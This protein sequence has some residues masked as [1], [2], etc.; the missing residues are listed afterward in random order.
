M[1]YWTKPNHNM[2]A[3]YQCSSIPFVTSSAADEVDDTTPVS[4]H[5]PGVTRWLEIR[6]TG[7]GDLKI[8]FT[9]NGILGTGAVSGSM[10]PSITKASGG[11]LTANHANYFTLPTAA[12][13]KPT[14]TTRW[15]LK[16]NKIWFICSSG[17]TDFTLI[18]G[19]T[20]IPNDHFTQLSGSAGYDGVG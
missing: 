10:L 5:F 9:Q 8:G 12:A 11:Q 6:N 16:T 4:V 14:S 3:E 15:E 18:A 17:T 20:N 13:G 1:A 7:A 2:S 19:I